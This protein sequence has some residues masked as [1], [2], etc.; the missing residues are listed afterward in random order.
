LTVGTTTSTGPG[1]AGSAAWTTATGS[2]AWAAEASLGFIFLDEFSG[3]FAFFGVEP[4]VFV[5]VELGD[6]GQWLAHAHC[7]WAAGLGGGRGLGLG[8][9][10]AGGDGEG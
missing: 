5:G 6:Y 9:D 10:K 3:G 2:T 8:G 4:A 1:R 7:G